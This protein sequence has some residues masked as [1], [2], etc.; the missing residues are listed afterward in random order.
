MNKSL[1]FCGLCTIF[2]IGAAFAQE[3]KPLSVEDKAKVEDILKSFDPNS[4][5]I[6]FSYLDSQGKVQK[7]QIGKA[8]GLAD[9]K[10]K[11]T[12]RADKNDDT[13]SSAGINVYKEISAG[14]NVTVFKDFRSNAVVNVYGSV[15]N[16]FKDAKL[17]AKAQEL[18][19]GL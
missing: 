3:L 11:G 13:R 1:L 10:Q 2:V 19:K 14:G 18:I 4:F 16:A 17:Q 7:S 6:R 5:D 8:K 12:K 15:I 9:L